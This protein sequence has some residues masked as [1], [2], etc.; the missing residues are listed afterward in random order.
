MIMMAFYEYVQ[1]W[2]H[3]KGMMIQGLIQI[4]HVSY[5]DMTVIWI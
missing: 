3:V 5:Y 4:T 1:L 2:D